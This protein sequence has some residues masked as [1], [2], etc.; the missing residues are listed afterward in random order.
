MIA[1]KDLKEVEKVSLTIYPAFTSIK[2]HKNKYELSKSIIFPLLLLVE[3]LENSVKQQILL[4]FLVDDTIN[5]YS[6][7][8]ILKDVKA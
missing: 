3:I 7:A 4:I 5:G 8:N 2:N 6:Y 1:L